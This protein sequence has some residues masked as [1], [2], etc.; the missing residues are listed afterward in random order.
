MNRF[1]GIKKKEMKTQTNPGIVI[2]VAGFN[3]CLTFSAL[4]ILL[5]VLQISQIL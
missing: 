1:D 2:K 3:R 5:I 4:Q